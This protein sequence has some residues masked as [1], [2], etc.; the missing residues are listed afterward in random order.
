M[1]LNTWPNLSIFTM[2]SHFI[3][4][5]F[6]IFSIFTVE[7]TTSPGDI[8]AL[9]A[10]K[11]AVKP[12]S[13]PPTSCLATWN[14]STD[15]CSAPRTTDFT[16]G[17]TCSG[18]RVIQLTLDSQS[19]SGTLSP[20][21]SK[22]TRLITLDLSDNAFYGT[23][24]SSISSLLNLKSLILRANYFEGSIPSSLTNL[25]SLETLDVSHNSL[26][27]TLPDMNSLTGLANLDV[28]YNN[29]T[30][31]IP[32]LPPNL[33]ELAIKSNS[34]SG[35]LP[36]YSFSGMA[37]LM[38][39][40]LSDNLF[41]GTLDSWLFL[42]P[43]LQQVN[44]SNNSFT[45]AF[46]AKPPSGFGSDLVAV[47]LSFNKIEGLLPVNFTE[48][49]MLRSLALSHNHFRGP[50]PKQFS[51]M[52]YLQRL[53]LDGNYLNG[54]PPAGLFAGGGPVSGSLG[55]N[56]LE[57]CPVSSE[58]CSKLQKPKSVCQ[59]AYGGKHEVSRVS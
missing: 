29:L 28:S 50:I 10:F 41:S 57:N 24:P 2:P 21:I 16:C 34:L 14:F 42:L 49:P 36:I 4:P 13:I 52:E 17:V 45:I 7:S 46:V 27:G 11:S 40:E 15:P 31:N 53:Y 22:L 37:L 38:V 3:L 56:C 51:R 23:I 26:S 19:Y 30:E 18:N 55:D 20:L 33:K 32:I 58:L 1:A 48:Y 39:L 43:S 9:M 54:S 12:A 8:T 5:F 6:F 59:Q 44:L 25:K 47:D 35:Y